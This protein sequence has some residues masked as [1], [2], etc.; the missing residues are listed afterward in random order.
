LNDIEIYTGVAVRPCAAL[1]RP[2]VPSCSSDMLLFCPSCAGHLD[3]N[4]Q[5]R[6][7]RSTD[8]HISLLCA[9]VPRILDNPAKQ[10]LYR[11]K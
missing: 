2:H 1:P 7:E 10:T 6:L 9:L 5:K 11:S 4:S 8:T 3:T